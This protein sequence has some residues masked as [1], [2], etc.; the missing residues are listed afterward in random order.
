VLKEKNP[1]EKLKSETATTTGASTHQTQQGDTLAS[2]S[3]LH[4]GTAETA[5]NAAKILD[6]N[7]DRL[8]WWW[9]AQSDAGQNDALTRPLPAGILLRIPGAI[10]GGSVVDIK[11]EGVSPRSKRDEPAVSPKY[12]D[13]PEGA[14]KEPLHGYKHADGSLQDAQ[15]KD[16]AGGGWISG[17]FEYETTAFARDIGLYYG[18]LKWGFYYSY[19]GITNAYAKLAPK[20][21][22]TFN[23]AI[24]SFNKVYK[25]KHVVLEGETL[26]SISIMYFGSTSGAHRIY[27]MNRTNPALTTDDPTAPIKGGTELEVGVGPSVWDE[28]RSD[29]GKQ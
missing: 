17:P 4:Y 10:H 23:A 19:A 22:D 12:P 29:A 1:Y 15:M 16:L 24:A 21:S 7:R 28:F 9:L 25:N 14:F 2:V 20:V 8:G 27:L 11:P 3:L 26:N 6:K 18:A 5:E 13:T